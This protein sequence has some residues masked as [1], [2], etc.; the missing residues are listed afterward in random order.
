MSL[1]LSKF[2]YFKNTPSDINEHFD[3]LLKYASECENIV[4]FGIRGICSTWAFLA[5]KPKKLISYDIKNPEYFGGNLDEIIFAA[6]ESNIEFI[7]IE[8]DTTK[9]TI[10]N[11]D[12]LFIDTWHTYDQLSLELKIH[13]SNVNKYIILHDTTTYEWK[14]E[15]FQHVNTWSNNF[16]GGGLWKAVNEFLEIN[17]LWSIKERFVNNNGLTVIQ[18]L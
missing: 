12:L 4:E 11:T 9:I 15:T 14:D 10:P 1:I 5:A 18:K 6:K 16:I 3:T 2:E 17:P 7:F 13:A 8:G